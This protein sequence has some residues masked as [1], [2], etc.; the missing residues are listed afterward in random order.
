[1]IAGSIVFGLWKVL[2][3]AL[4]AWFCAR[5]SEMELVARRWVGYLRA[6]AVKFPT[7]S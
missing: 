6:I 3:K 2:R 4:P 7:M 1:M 5:M